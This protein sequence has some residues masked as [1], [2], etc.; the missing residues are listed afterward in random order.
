[1]D[2]FKRSRIASLLSIVSTTRFLFLDFFAELLEVAMCAQC[3]LIRIHARLHGRWPDNPSSRITEARICEVPLYL[4]SYLHFFQTFA[5][6]C[7][8]EVNMHALYYVIMNLFLSLSWKLVVWKKYPLRNIKL[9]CFF[10]THNALAGTFCLGHTW[11]W[12]YMG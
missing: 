3:A 5:T 10:K 4:C 2:H 6:C 1:M 12:Q 11:Q 7:R 8:Q 9:F